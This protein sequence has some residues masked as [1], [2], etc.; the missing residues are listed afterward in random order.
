MMLTLHYRITQNNHT[1]VNL[2]FQHFCESYL[3][4]I[5]IDPQEPL[6]SPHQTILRKPR[7]CC[8]VRRCRRWSTRWPSSSNNNSINN[9]ISSSQHI[10]SS[11]RWITTSITSRPSTITPTTTTQRI[12]ILSITIIHSIIISWRMKLPLLLPPQPRTRRNSSSRRPARTSRTSRIWTWGSSWPTGTRP[13]RR[14][15]WMGICR[16]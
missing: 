9:N 7:I 6:S 13:R 14:T 2:Q 4:S 15:A 12:C 8:Q 3:P 5:E 10:R 16:M 11:T 1:H